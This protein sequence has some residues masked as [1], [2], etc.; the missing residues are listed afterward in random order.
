MRH[1]FIIGSRGLPARYG[2]FETLTEELTGRRS[3]EV[4]AY[5]VAAR[6]GNSDLDRGRDRFDY[7]GVDCFV[8]DIPRLGPAAAIYYDLMAIRRALQICR[9]ELPGVKPVFYILGNTIGGFIAP[10]VAAIHRIGGQVYV[11]PDGLEWR[12][13]KWPAP[14]RSYFRYAE[15]MMARHADLLVCDSQAIARYLGRVYA[16][17]RPDTRF[18]AYGTD[19]SPS[20]LSDTSPQVRDWYTEH[21][22]KQ[23]EYYLIVG[24]FVPE[25]NI[26]TMVGEYLSTNTAKPLVLITKPDNRGL[27]TRLRALGAQDDP[28]VR[29]VGT[30][31]DHD[32][33]KYIRS[34][35]YAY[36]HGHEVGGTNPSLLEAMAATPL[37]LLLDVPFNREVAQDAA[38]YWTKEP[39]NLAALINRVEELPAAQYQQF[40]P[41][42]RQIVTTRYN[43]PDIVAQYEALFQESA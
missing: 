28:R 38:L 27:L 13:A 25:N 31:Y 42:A 4:I 29:F 17:Y 36:L 16:R 18:I 43:W 39:G 8:V 10:V 9:T 40:G 2:G 5:H 6:R 11:N 32:L 41:A 15:K 20:T 26:E 35:A 22:L 1:V 12:R 7:H 24:R 34:H 30:V 21:G 33:L 37:N 14:V 23:G 19:L 3:P